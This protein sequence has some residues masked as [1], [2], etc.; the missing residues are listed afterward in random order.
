MSTQLAFISYRRADSGAAVLALRD[1]LQRVFGSQAIFVDVETIR[2]AQ[3]WRQSIDYAL[4]RARL[5]LVVI[6]PS[7]LKSHDEFGQ[8]RLDKED[9]WVRAE[10][11]HAIDKELPIVPLLVNGATLPPEHGVP[12]ALRRLTEHQ[13]YELRSAHWE[14]DLSGL[15]GA[16]EHFGFRRLGTAVKYPPPTIFPDSLKP[17][18]LEAA[19]QKLPHWT[20]EVSLVPGQ[21][22]LKRTELMRIF[23][24]RSFDDAMA[25]MQRASLHVSQVNHHPR[26]ENIY[27][28]VTVWLTTWNIGHKPS[29]FDIEVASYFEGLFASYSS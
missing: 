28:T 3:N 12:F 11:L 22:P 15:V 17:H 4:Q 26:W 19:M 7:W 8:R 29:T 24:F 10:V 16:L 20:I 5:L 18:E 21:E 6:G 1:F 2:T 13:S 25:F 9:D 14:H 27:R 23:Q